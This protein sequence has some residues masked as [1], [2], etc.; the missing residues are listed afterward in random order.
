MKKEPLVIHLSA[1]KN[2]REQSCASI[3]RGLE[4]RQR[5]RTVAGQGLCEVSAARYGSLPSRQA[6]P[7]ASLAAQDT[8]QGRLQAVDGREHKEALLVPGALSRA[9][10]QPRRSASALGISLLLTT[11]M[12]SPS[13]CASLRA[14]ARTVPSAT[15]EGTAPSSALRLSRWPRPPCCWLPLSAAAAAV[16]ARRQ[17]RSRGQLASPLCPGQP[18]EPAL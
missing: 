14:R 4:S 13:A 10:L 16:R 8:A 1:R 15:A 17:R 11:F 9:E 6:A 12:I 7:L 18:A 5:E 3:G 2:K